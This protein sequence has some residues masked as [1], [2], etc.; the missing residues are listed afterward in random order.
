MKPGI[1]GCVGES[2]WPITNGSPGTRFTTIAP[3]PPA[4]CTL[5]SLTLNVACAARQQRDLAAEA[6]GG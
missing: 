1:V 6:A 4:A 2:F 5:A 3:T